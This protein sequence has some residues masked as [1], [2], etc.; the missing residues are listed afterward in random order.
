MIIPV[1]IEVT[2]MVTKHLKNLEVIPER[3]STDSLQQTVIFGT[4]H[5]TRKVGLLKSETRSLSCGN[6]R[7]FKRKSARKKGL[8]QQTTTRKTTTT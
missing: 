6:H 5:I 3:Y 8:C 4:S 1:I 7:C 2:E